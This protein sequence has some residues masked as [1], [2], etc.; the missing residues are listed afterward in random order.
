MEESDSS[1]KDNSQS[2]D[3]SSRKKAKTSANESEAYPVFAC[4]FSKRHPVSHKR[5]YRFH[6]KRIRDVKQHLRR[7]HHNPIYCPVCRRVFDDEDARDRHV[8]ARTCSPNF[9]PVVHG[10]TEA[11][12]KKLGERCTTGVSEENQWFM[13]F[14]IV[15]PGCARPK[16]PYVDPLLTEELRSFQDFQASEGPQIVTDYF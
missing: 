12:K 14:D 15:F 11:Q 10:I 2:S 1:Q 4:P 8:I 7:R 13:V 3:W 16:S 6:L 5:C 9:M